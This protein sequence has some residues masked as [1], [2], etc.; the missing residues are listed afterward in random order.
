[1]IVNFI[2][3][4]TTMSLVQQ[5]Y[6]FHNGSVQRRT[7]SKIV[8]FLNYFLECNNKVIKGLKFVISPVTIFINTFQGTCEN[9]GF[10]KFRQKSQFFSKIVFI[11]QNMR[12][13]DLHPW[14]LKVSKDPKETFSKL[15]ID[16]RVIYG[17]LRKFRISQNISIF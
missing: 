14:D 4:L 12:F 11:S 15:K 1:M 17:T 16:M 2:S 7:S 6:S 13:M 5:N 8:E 3:Q 9:G 10:L